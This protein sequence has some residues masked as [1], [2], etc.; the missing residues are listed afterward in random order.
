MKFKQN[1]CVMWNATCLEIKA[2]WEEACQRT[3]S[4]AYE[5]TLT[6]GM[7]GTHSLTSGH[8]EA[9]SL[10]FQSCDVPFELRK[11][12]QLAAQELLGS[13]YLVLL[14]ADHFHIQKNRGVK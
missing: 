1:T 14:E 4:M 6:S 13:D 5:P 2:A 8:Y 3:I 12:V 9:R 11:N 10:D 7:D